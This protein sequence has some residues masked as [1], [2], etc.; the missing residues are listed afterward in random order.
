MANYLDTLSEF[1]AT[2]RFEHLPGETVAA[3]KDVVMDTVGAIV[4]GNRLPENV[5]FGDLVAERSGSP[6]AT[7][8]GR[9]HRAEPMMATLVNSTI[10]VCLEMDEGNGFGGGHPSIHSMPGT[11]AVAEEMGA[12]GTQFL[13]AFVAAY[14]VE[15]RISRATRNRP[16]A[17]SH[18]HWGAVGT[19]AGVARL[20]GFDPART[21]AA[22]NLAASMSP[23]NTWTPCFEGATIRN[24]YPG[25]SGF[26]G[27]LAVH[28]HECGFTGVADGPTD[29]YGTLVGD[30][31]DQ[32]EVV[33]GLGT[34]P[35]RIEQNYF[36][37]HACCRINH[38]SLD[39]VLA[40]RGD[41]RITPEDIQAVEVYSGA[42]DLSE[43]PLAGMVGPY[44]P[45]M[46]SAKFNI[47]YA[48]AATL[49]RGNADYTAFDPKAIEDERVRSMATKVQV[50]ADPT[51]ASGRDGSD[52]PLARAS[53]RLS[54]GRELRGDTTIVRGDWGNRAPREELIDK[55]KLLSTEIIGEE[56]VGAS[57]DAID[58][59]PA[60]DDVRELTSILGQ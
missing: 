33:S 39:A 15:T 17:H 12:S 16:G 44:P 42:R 21:K 32:D 14:E 13:E 30:H 51:L 36:K 10:G 31:F 55:F 2:R 53:I 47:P 57:L 49:V 11:L 6:T 7:I 34:G 26:Q 59:L 45:N 1:V 35:Y 29:V 60:L 48:V 27:I 22:M 52:G 25:R 58:R 5:A 4:G 23:A 28:L 56:R 18:G 9:P 8:L 40:A 3:A 24:L 41:E 54:D 19:A 43:G 46:L 38:P 20:K 37:F 50:S